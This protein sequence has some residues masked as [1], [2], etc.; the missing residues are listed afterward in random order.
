MYF[1][2]KSKSIL[3]TIS[4]SQQY[5]SARYIEV[6]K[7]NFLEKKKDVSSI[8]CQ[9]KVKGYRCESTIRTYKG[10]LK[11]TFTVTKVL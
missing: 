2:S 10:P 5:K 11:I 8:F 9:T 1:T 3:D 4:L 6:L 7:K